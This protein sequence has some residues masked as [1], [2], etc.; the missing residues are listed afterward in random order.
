VRH[1]GRSARPAAEEPP[2]VPAPRSCPDGGAAV[3]RAGARCPPRGQARKRQTLGATE[4][5][6]DGARA[7][8][9]ARG[10]ASVGLVPHIARKHGLDAD[11][12]RARSGPNRTQPLIAPAPS[13]RLSAAFKAA[14]TGEVGRRNLRPDTTGTKGVPFSRQASIR[15]SHGHRR[16]PGD[17]T[18]VPA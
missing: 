10:G 12:S 15:T 1:W 4:P 11:R 6:A 17:K 16:P 13:A 9:H 14:S 5:V 2:P 7:R 3:P 8:R 18:R